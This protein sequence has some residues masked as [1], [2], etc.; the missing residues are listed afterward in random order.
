MS[1]N[2]KPNRCMSD[3][4]NPSGHCMSATFFWITLYLNKYH[5]IGAKTKKMSVFCT[6]YIVKMAVTIAMIL[7]FIFLAFSRVYLGV[8]SYN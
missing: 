6:A 4:G 1:E 3:Y 7:F 2:I 8:H 5:D